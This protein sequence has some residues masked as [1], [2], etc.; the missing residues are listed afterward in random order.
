[1]FRSILKNQLSNLLSQ[2]KETLISLC[3]QKV[4]N[5]GQRKFVE[6][7]QPCT[8]RSGE[9][10]QSFLNSRGVRTVKCASGIISKS[11]LRLLAFH[12]I[13]I[14]GPK[15]YCLPGFFRRLK[16]HGGLIMVRNWDVVKLWQGIGG[17]IPIKSNVEIKD[18]PIAFLLK[19]KTK[20]LDRSLPRLGS[21]DFGVCFD[22]GN[23]RWEWRYWICAS[24]I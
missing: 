8:H 9:A 20:L 17:I 3:Y 19:E 4:L 18:L 6:P 22:S 23:C 5:L 21:K 13:T 16:H 1:M 24:Q 11:G 14:K 2:K 12:L 15:E 10:N 7:F